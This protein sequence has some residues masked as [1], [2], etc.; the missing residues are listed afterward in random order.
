MLSPLARHCEQ[1]E[2]IQR[3]TPPL[4]CFVAD[5]RLPRPRK[6]APTLTAYLSPCPSLRAKRSNP[7][8]HASSGLLRR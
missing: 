5:G 1:S 8:E 2:A 7:A 6:D 4:D 3:E